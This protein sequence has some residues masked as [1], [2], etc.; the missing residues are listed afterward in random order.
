MATYTDKR[1][2]GLYVQFDID[3]KTYKKAMPRNSDEAFAAEYE[4]KWRQQIMRD[5]ISRGLETSLDG[6]LTVTSRSQRGI[7]YL[8]R[9]GDLYKLGMTRNIT[10]RL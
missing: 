1:T 2:G 10:R 3:H 8:L 4:A 6:D 5:R 9:C 7:V